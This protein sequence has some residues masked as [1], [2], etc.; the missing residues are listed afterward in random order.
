MGF[1]YFMNTLAS[2]ASVNQAKFESTDEA[3]IE[4]AT[5]EGT[6]VEKRDF[7]GW[8]LTAWVY[9]LFRPDEEYQQRG[10]KSINI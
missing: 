10:T 2:V 4:H 5:K 6:N 7:M 1:S 3:I 8:D 9:D